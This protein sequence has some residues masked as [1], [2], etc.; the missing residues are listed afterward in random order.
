A[1]IEAA[2]QRGESAWEGSSDRIHFG[3]DIA[4]YGADDSVVVI[5]QGRRIL[6]IESWHG[7]NLMETTGRI[8]ALAAQYKPEEINVDDAG[9]GGGVTDRLEELNQPVH[10]V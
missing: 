5:R 3:A 10:G 4:R 8:V 2:R 7:N 9:V 6:K 1:W